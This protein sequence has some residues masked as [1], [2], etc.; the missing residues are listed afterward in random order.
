MAC[1]CLRPL[2]D[3]LQQ[4]LHCLYFQK[5][6]NEHYYFLACHKFLPICTA[7]SFQHPRTPCSK[8]CP[9]T[10]V[11]QTSARMKLL[12]LLCRKGDGAERKGSDAVTQ[13]SDASNRRRATEEQAPRSRISSAVNYKI[14]GCVFSVLPIHRRKAGTLTLPTQYLQYHTSQ[15]N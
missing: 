4:E 15:K 8:K 12:L 13:G 10:C 2:A 3:T 9:K 1:T 7:S 5:L 11:L 14:C 6:R